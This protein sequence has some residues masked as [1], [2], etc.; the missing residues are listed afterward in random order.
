MV[1]GMESLLAAVNAH[2]PG[3]WE[4]LQSRVPKGEEPPH[5]HHHYNHCS[6]ITD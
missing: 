4:L 1:G 5:H 2:L 6:A 3:L